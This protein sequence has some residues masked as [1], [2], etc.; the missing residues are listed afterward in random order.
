MKIKCMTHCKSMAKSTAQS[1]D[2]YIK[3][4]E[5]YQISNQ[6][7]QNPEEVRVNQS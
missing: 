4:L 1:S 6:S 5:R 7:I 3:K 2:A